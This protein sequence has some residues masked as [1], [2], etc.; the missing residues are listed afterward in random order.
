MS[1]GVIRHKHTKV[2]N[3]QQHDI[4]HLFVECGV[5]L[6]HYRCTPTFNFY[7]VKDSDRYR[8]DEYWCC[9][10]C[11]EDELRLLGQEANLEFVQSRKKPRA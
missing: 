6:S 11:I 7:V 9:D 3:G 8:K 4:R 1:V 5:C 10:M 2:A